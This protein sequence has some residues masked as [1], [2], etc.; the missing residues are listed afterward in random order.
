VKH[1]ASIVAVALAGG[2]GIGVGQGL[3]GGARELPRAYAQAPSFASSAE[4][5]T[6]IQV[7]KEARPAVVQVKRG[8]GSGSGV[9][10]RKDG[11]I[12]TNAHVVADAKQV[13]VSLGTGKTLQARVLGVDPTV[14]IAVVKVEATNLPVASFGDSDHLDVGQTAIAI[15]NPY[16]FEGTVTTGVVSAT[17]RQRSL[18]DFVGFIQTDAAIN[19]GNSGG[20]LLDSRGRV[21]GINTWIVGRAT[22]LGFAVP[23]NV[24]RDVARQVME[25]GKVHRVIIGVVPG[26]VTKEIA[27]KLSLPVQKGAVVLEVSKDSPA[28]KAGLKAEDIIT[29]IDGREIAGA[30]DL[31]KLLRDRKAGDSVALTVLRG[32]NTLK[33]SVTLVEGE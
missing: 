19:P 28:E 33:T 6:V 2:I 29:H 17:N 14:D 18:D 10:I 23:I 25:T 24:A 21:I 31:R 15:G 32:S 26:S 9:I 30:G 12:L 27:E 16:G 22:G 20:P 5:A 13:D 8:Q 4:E 3:V 1:T 7:A 11:V